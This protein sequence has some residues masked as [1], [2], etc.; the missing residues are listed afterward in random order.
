VGK[1]G[2]P[3]ALRFGA[4]WGKSAGSEKLGVD[5]ARNVKMAHEDCQVELVEGRTELKV[6]GRLVF[7]RACQVGSP[8]ALPVHVGG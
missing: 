2:P 4:F 8:A 1:E 7:I 5:L 6:W 3:E